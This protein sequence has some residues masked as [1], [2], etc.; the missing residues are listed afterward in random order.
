MFR[1]YLRDH[2]QE[3]ENY[4]ALKIRLA[5]T[6]TSGIGAYLD[7]KQ[8]YILQIIEKA[9]EAGY[10]SQSSLVSGTAKTDK[11]EQLRNRGQP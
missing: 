7:G 4:E 3:A 9:V 2:L 6:T 11:V 5:Q 10:G 1:D 8:S